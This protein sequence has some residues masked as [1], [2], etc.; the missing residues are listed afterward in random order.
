MATNNRLLGF[1]L[2]VFLFF[3]LFSV[4]AQN[5]GYYIDT[6]GQRL[7]QRLAW[8]GGEYALRYE[9]V[10]E[11]GSGGTYRNYHREFTT[12]LYI[13]ISLQPGSYRFRV[14]PYDIL[15]RP[16]AA[17]EWKYI[18]VLPALKPQPLAVLPEYI[19]GADGEGILL[20]I[21]GDNLDPEAEI[22][23][24]R[25]D[26]TQVAAET[27]DFS[28]GDGGTI[29]AF[30]ESDKFIP[31]EY[32]IVIRNP[33]GL[34]ASI[35]G[36]SL[37]TETGPLGETHT[38][39]EE[40]VGQIKPLKPVEINF[41]LAFMPSFLVYGEN[42]NGGISVLG[43]VARA[44]LLF[45]IPAG[46]YIGPELSALIY[47]T[48][49]IDYYGMS[50]MGGFE[51]TEYIYDSVT[52]MVGFNLLVRKW[53]PGQRAALSFR[54]GVDFG[55]LPDWIDQVSFRMDVSFILRFTN[56]MQL[57]GGLDYSHLLSENPGGFFRPWL[58]ITFQL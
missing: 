8:S 9:V 47:Y 28:D 18:D 1:F 30:V 6:G 16:G 48:D 25:E 32:E 43:L 13:D 22:F 46:V 19:T 56:K 15:N 41:G 34:E 53:F 58:G 14:I 40:S 21:T 52:L 7:V 29:I 54:A 55:I 37:L 5:S 49:Y 42:I 36:V 23:I 38:G 10:I 45:Y 27:L 12:E 51:Y 24:R 50:T 17:S 3:G 4:S 26:G 31:G 57:E 20:Y 39:K 33:G 2:A 44:N 11:N 35:D